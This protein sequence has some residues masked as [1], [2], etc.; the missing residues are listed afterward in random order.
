MRCQG[1]TAKGDRCTRNAVRG[2][3]LCASHLGRCGAREGN[4]NA[5]KHGFY[6]EH[7]RKLRERLLDARDV[8]GLEQEIAL[9]RVEILAIVQSPEFDAVAFVQLVN[10][11]RAALLAQKKLSG[12]QADEI[13][14]ALGTILETVAEE[15]GLGQE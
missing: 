9:C 12:E 4:R 2:A 7:A 14:G 3:K 10:A 15:I 8:G 13:A 1:E 5:L 11:L 6:S